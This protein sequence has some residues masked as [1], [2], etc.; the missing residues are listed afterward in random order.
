[1]DTVRNAG[2]CNGSSWRERFFP[3]GGLGNLP[4]KDAAFWKEVFTGKSTILFEICMIDRF[5]L[6]G[7][8]N[9]V[10]KS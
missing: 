8:E 4:M 9:N 2:A 10:R 6:A 7:E 1:M 5:G 3:T